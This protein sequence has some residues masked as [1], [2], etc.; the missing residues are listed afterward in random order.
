MINVEEAQ[1]II[2]AK[3]L[4]V[5]TER[6]KIE[7]SLGRINKEAIFADRDF[8]PFDRVTMDGLAIC[9]DEKSTTWPIENIQLAGQAQLILRDLN[10]GIEIMTGAM[11]PLG[12]D[13]IIRYED[14]DIQEVN[15]QKV[16]MLRS[17]FPIIIQG[18]NIHWQGSDRQKGALLIPEN[19]T[20]FP[21]EIAV[22][23]SVGAAQILVANQPKVAIISTGDELVDVSENPLPYQI[24]KSNGLMLSTALQSLGITASLFHLQDDIPILTEAIGKILAQYDVLILSGGVSA[25]KA[26]FIPQVLENLGVVKHF[27]QVAQRPGKPF[28]FGTSIDDK[29]VFALPGNPV[30]TFV[31][32]L[33]Y[34]CPILSPAARFQP[35]KAALATPITFKPNLTYFVPV[36][37]ECDQTGRNIAYPLA[38]NGSGDF[39]N[40]LE[41]N[42]FLELPKDETL[43]EAGQVFD[44]LWFR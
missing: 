6:I 15:G 13:T 4:K 36:R 24:R 40:L 9:F 21:A 18:Q 8:P 33:K 10:A 43:F 25:G 5:S 28:W 37:V 22:A 30:S 3:S 42:A 29:M 39:A 19:T 32:F 41:A 7:K 34:V 23:A 17:P 31:C 35:Q 27:H 2:K 38:G 12:T 11:L 14:L 20:L 16:A 44:V 1:S 26:D